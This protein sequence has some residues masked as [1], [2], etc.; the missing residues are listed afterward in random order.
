VNDETIEPLLR[1][2]SE[3]AAVV[4][5]DMDGGRASDLWTGNLMDDGRHTE[6]FKGQK[7]IGPTDAT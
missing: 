7:F 5:L 1:A 4:G 2:A 6:P 3:I